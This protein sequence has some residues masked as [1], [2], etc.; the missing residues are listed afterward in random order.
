V[1]LTRLERLGNVKRNSVVI[2][3]PEYHSAG[4]LRYNIFMY[5]Q[6]CKSLEGQG[7]SCYEWRPPTYY[8][9]IHNRRSAR[10]YL[11]HDLVV[12]VR[13]ALSYG[14]SSYR[15]VE[16]KRD[17]V[18]SGLRPTILLMHLAMHILAVFPPR[19]L[20]YP[21][22]LCACEVVLLS[23][24]CPASLPVLSLTPPSTS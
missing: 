20:F 13:V 2:I 3:I 1:A 4:R 16:E 24:R 12:C 22:A 11:K 8:L 15:P 23:N 10:S 7:Y 14:T 19:R 5:H 21:D 6:Q 9:S 17:T 18:H